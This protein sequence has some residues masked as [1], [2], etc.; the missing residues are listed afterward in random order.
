MC[1][2]NEPVEAILREGES[3]KSV[4]QVWKAWSN[5]LPKAYSVQHHKAL[6]YSERPFGDISAV[7]GDA[8]VTKNTVY[9]IRE[10]RGRNSQ[11]IA[12]KESSEECIAALLG[13]SASFVEGSLTNG[14]FVIQMRGFDGAALFAACLPENLMKPT[15][16][17]VSA[18]SGLGDIVGFCRG[19]IFI[20]ARNSAG[21]GRPVIDSAKFPKTLDSQPF[22]R[23]LTA[24][25]SG[26]RWNVLQYLDQFGCG[27]KLKHA[28]LNGL[29]FQTISKNQLTAKPDHI[30]AFSETNMMRT[31][32]S[33]R[34]KLL[35]SLTSDRATLVGLEKISRKRFSI[36]DYLN[37]SWDNSGWPS[38]SGMKWESAQLDVS[39][40]GLFIRGISLL[41]CHLLIVATKSRPTPVSVLQMESRGFDELKSTECVVTVFVLVYTLETMTLVKEISFPSLCFKQRNQLAGNCQI[42]HLVS[43][44]ERK[45]WI[46]LEGS[47]FEG[48]TAEFPGLVCFD[49]I[50]GTLK[51][52]RKDEESGE[53]RESGES[54]ES[55]VRGKQQVKEPWIKWRHGPE[56]GQRKGVWI[57]HGGGGGGCSG[58]RYGWLTLC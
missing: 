41:R 44:D 45:L 31:D 34:E 3:W 29:F 15:Y 22:H 18:V 25:I 36:S 4:L 7:F 16:M 27:G 50:E 38:P 20:L 58:R 33:V 51:C 13:S 6:V 54:G 10:S 5:P 26:N 24:E 39:P 53:S 28:S 21:S 37:D 30:L 2:S 14:G 23:I 11:L 12:N 8:R 46:W 49:V 32:Q 47:G 35:K 52:F 1:G 17:R 19:S 40:R 55:R 9:Y 57:V 56:G 42:H 48:L 43:A